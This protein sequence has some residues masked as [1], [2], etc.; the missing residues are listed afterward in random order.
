MKERREPCAAD[1]AQVVT[2]LRGAVIMKERREPRAAAGRARRLRLRTHPARGTGN[3]RSRDAQSSL[4]SARN[5]RA[6]AYPGSSAAP[7]QKS[8]SVA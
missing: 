4:V 8:A 7:T 1:R 6:S 2:T 3:R 5:C